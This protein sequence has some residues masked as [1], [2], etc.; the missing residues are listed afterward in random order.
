MDTERKNSKSSDNT[1]LKPVSTDRGAILQNLYSLS[2]KE[3]LDRILALDNPQSLIKKL[4]NEDFFW[5]VK[6]VGE[7]DC[8]PLLKLASEDQWEYLLDLEL[9][10]KDRNVSLVGETT[11]IRPQKTYQMV[12]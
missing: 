9:W 8:L 7:D 12:V 6:K 11:A 4:P 1:E 10:E 3:T 2:G 5:L